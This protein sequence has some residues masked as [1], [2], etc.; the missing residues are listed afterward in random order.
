MAQ[1]KTEW[2]KRPLFRYLCDAWLKANPEKTKRDLGILMG[3]PDELNFKQYYSGSQN[4]SRARRKK[5]ALV[6]GCS[7]QELMDDEES[8]ANMD[9]SIWETTDIRLKAEAETMFH[10][11]KSLPEDKRSEFIEFLKKSH[12]IAFTAF[13]PRPK[14]K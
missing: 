14:K 11:A 4:P 1:A 13:E 3:M 6:I 12:E 10:L 9:P 7:E 5:M 2:L 8:P